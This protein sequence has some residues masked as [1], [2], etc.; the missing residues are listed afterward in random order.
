MNIFH[1]MRQKDKR[2]HALGGV[3]AAVFAALMALVAVHIAYGVAAWITGAVLAFGFEALQKYRK[4]GEAS[5]DDAVA[6][7]VGTT[8]V[9][10]LLLAL[11]FWILPAYFA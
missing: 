10:A 11:E 7:L 1:L 5:L 4:E 2:K 9:A 6:G 3:F 8:P